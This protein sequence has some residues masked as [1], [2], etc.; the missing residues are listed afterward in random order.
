M[1]AADTEETHTVLAGP[2]Y[3]EHVA[4]LIHDHCSGCHSEG[5][6]APLQLSTYEQVKNFGERIK[7]ATA[8]RI[9]PPFLP[10]NS[11]KCGTYFDANW[12]SDA[13]IALLG[14]W[15]DNGMPEGEPE[16]PLAPLAFAALDDATNEARM[17]TNY[18]PDG[19][20]A[21][22]YRCFLLEDDFT[23]SAT[24]Y[25]TEFEVVPGDKRVVHHVIAYQPRNAA[26]VEQARMMAAQDERMGYA[27]FG[28]SGITGARMLMNWAP[29]GGVVKHPEGTG[30][31]VDPS[32]PLVLQVHYNTA[33][34]VFEDQTRIRM[35]LAPE[36][37]HPMTPWFYSD[38]QLTLP[39]GQ[40]EVEKLITTPFAAVRQFAGETGSGP[41]TI[42]GVRAH[43]HTLGVKMEIERI[44]GGD[45]TCLLSIPRY[46]FHWQRSYF[47]QQPVSLDPAD[48]LRVRCVY[49]T[50]K[51]TTPT[52]WGEGTSDEMCLATIYTIDGPYTP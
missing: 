51:R 36:V 26:G 39:P 38:A 37:R 6:I 23:G 45:P 12:L 40:E 14:S 28:S 1:P 11:G 18:L 31:P 34:G 43:M 44:A 48:S 25:L 35:K 47:L 16:E 27:C 19:A 8:A 50:R 49:D 5:G 24:G 46:N 33:G 15:V 32:L 3:S 9:M 29:G 22:D 2:T 42:M 4:P 52:S 20:L 21:D 7:V 10:D 13:Q 41:M 17:E 30:V